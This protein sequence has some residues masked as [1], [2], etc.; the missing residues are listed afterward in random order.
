MSNSP[1]SPI[2]KIA[3]FL[4][5]DGGNDA[6]AAKPPAPAGAV[7]VAVPT[8]APAAPAAPVAPQ[9]PTEKRKRDD[10]D[11]EEGTKGSPNVLTRLERA[12]KKM[13]TR[14]LVGTRSPVGPNDP[15]AALP[16]LPTTPRNF[17]SYIGRA[18]THMNPEKI[19]IM[20]GTPKKEEVNEYQATGAQFEEWMANT[21]PAGPVCPVAQS[22]LTMIDLLEAIKPNAPLF[23]VWE[24]YFSAPPSEISASLALTNLPKNPAS[25]D[26][27]HLTLQRNRMLGK[28]S[29]YEHYTVSGAIIAIAIFRRKYGP[30]WYDIALAL[31]K[32]DAAIDTL[33]YV[34]M[35]SVENDETLPLVGKVL[36]PNHNLPGY[37]SRDQSPTIYTWNMNTSD[38]QKILGTQLGRSVSR[39]VLAAWPAAC[40]CDLILSRL[41]QLALLLLFQN[42]GS[43]RLQS[44]LQSLLQE[45]DYLR[46]YLSDAYFMDY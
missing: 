33:R 5:L 20:G 36:Y 46:R 7:G 42:W 18:S 3:K 27:R 25:K 34:F 17:G 14:Y 4:G 29:T 45:L 44:L 31:Y 39:L 22:T 21:N 24:S 12:R 19:H 35:V 13:K 16:E 26:Y 11:K 28:V 9:G 41:V 1:G 15:G 10:D 32:R 37:D 6:K 30:Q 38:F 8:V 43:N 23:T 2:K 40:I